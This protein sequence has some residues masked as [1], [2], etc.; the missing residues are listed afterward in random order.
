MQDQTIDYK[1]TIYKKDSKGKIRHVTI[2][3]IGDELIQE[4]GILDGKVV[5]N[6]SKVKSKNI[7]KSNETTVTEQGILQAEA[8]LNKKLTQG[9]FNTTQ[10]AQDNEVILPM[11]AKSFKDNEKKIDKT[12]KVFVQPKLDGMRCFA[13][14]K[15]GTIKLMSRDGKNI[16]E[17]SRGAMQM[18]IDQL[19]YLNVGIHFI[20]DGELYAHGLNFQQNMSAI[21]KTNENTY[22]I[23][24]NVYDIVNENDFNTRNLYLNSIVEPT[25]NISIVE[26]EEIDFNDIKDKHNQYVLDG[27][28]G[29][30]VRHSNKPYKLNG[31]CDSLLKYKNFI[32]EVYEIT[33]V[34]PSDKKP[35]LGQFIL[36]CK[37]TNQTFGCVMKF[38]HDERKQILIDKDEYIG[39]SAE[40]RFFEYSDNGIPR[41]PICC[42]VRLDK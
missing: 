41:F 25:T 14:I 26:T 31:R 18:I 23:K 22:L 8:K 7:G 30:M 40:I 19:Q 12:K 32:D 3:V 6:K 20:L 42:G 4:S 24:Y 33:D 16:I 29:L 2:K 28:E 5:S 10:E 13:I 17:T 34:V 38:S 15:N 36:T 11:L 21:K 39:K 37:K 9:Y 1:R 35:D 27:Y